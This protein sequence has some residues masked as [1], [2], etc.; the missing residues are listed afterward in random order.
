MQFLNQS[1]IS[2]EEYYRMYDELDNERIEYLLQNQRDE[3]AF[4]DVEIG[5]EEAQAQYMGEDFL[6]DE[7]DQLFDLAKR[8]KGYNRETLN[9]L[10]SKIELEVDKEKAASEYRADEL[11]KVLKLINK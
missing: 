1:N 7:I 11:N 4:S 10:I 6:K 3:N 9:S 5:I 2:P 8:L